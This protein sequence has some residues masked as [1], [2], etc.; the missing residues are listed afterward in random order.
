MGDA[1]KLTSQVDDDGTDEE[2]DEEEGIPCPRCGGS[3]CDWCDGSGLLTIREGFAVCPICEG[4]GEAGWGVMENQCPGCSGEGFIDDQRLHEIEGGDWTELYSDIASATAN[5]GD[6]TPN[7][8][9][10]TTLM[11]SLMSISAR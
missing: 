2:E 7:R 11:P 4:S 5:T 8:S 10:G 3:G 1:E 9:V 6:A